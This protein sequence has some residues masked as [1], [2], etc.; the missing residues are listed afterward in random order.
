[1]VYW[2]ERD[3]AVMIEPDSDDDDSTYRMVKKM[4]KEVPPLLFHAQNTF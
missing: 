3:K 1:M 4:W 2:R